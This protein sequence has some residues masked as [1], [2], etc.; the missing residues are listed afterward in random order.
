[1]IPFGR[2]G[3]SMQ[4]IILAVLE[5]LN[6]GINENYFQKEINLIDKNYVFSLKFPIDF[7]HTKNGENTLPILTF[8][9]KT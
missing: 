1:M 3:Q 6:T 8:N 9:D 7:S 4:N 5:K 2:V